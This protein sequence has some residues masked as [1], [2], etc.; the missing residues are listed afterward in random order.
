MGQGVVQPLDRSNRTGSLTWAIVITRVLLGALLIVSVVVR[1]IAGEQSPGGFPP[2]AQAWLSAMDATGYLQPLLLLTEFTVGIALIIGRFVPLALIVFA[3]IQI[4]IT[5]FHLFLDPRPIRLVQI[6]LMS[7]ACV[8]LA[9]HYRRAFSPILQ[10]PPQA[11]LLTLR[12]ENQSRVSIV[13]RTLLG[14]L[15]VVTGLAKLLFGGPREPT[16]FVLAMQETGYLYTLLGLLEVLVGLA[17][18]IGR[19]VLLAL[20]VL[21]P[22]LVNILAYHLFI[23]LASP[24]ALVAVLATIAAAYL[25]WQE[26]ARVLQQNI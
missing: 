19:F 25:T 20:I 22:L 1:L 17:L 10:A 13:A 26:R 12:R 4:N 9:W 5:L 18:I 6:V 24:L 16:A 8:L 14:A 3:P 23:E 7:A 11:T 21:T 15:F 2:A